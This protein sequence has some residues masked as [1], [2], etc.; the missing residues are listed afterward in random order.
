MLKIHYTATA[1]EI[2]LAADVFIK[3][4]IVRR[5]IISAVLYFVVL[6]LGVDLIVVAENKIYGIIIAALAVYSLAGCVMQP[7]RVKKRVK[8]GL[9]ASSDENYSAE[10]YDDKIIIITEVAEPSDVPDEKNSS[11]PQRGGEQKKIREISESPGEQP[12]IPQKT[13]ISEI[14]LAGQNLYA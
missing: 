8:R 3:K 2:L 11:P 9:S 14:P 1:D 6:I 5:K 13:A 7:F 4:Y 10:F 12:K